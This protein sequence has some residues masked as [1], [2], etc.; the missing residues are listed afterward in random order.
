MRLLYA[1]DVDADQI[2]ATIKSRGGIQKLADEAAKPRREGAK[3]GATQGDAESEQENGEA[4]DDAEL[5]STDAGDGDSEENGDQNEDP[6][7]DVEE[8]ADADQGGVRFH[9]SEKLTE[10]IRKCRGKRIKIIARVPRK[11]NEKVRVLKVVSLKA[12]TQG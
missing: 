12:A 2:A 10:K 1:E 6:V 11:M 7:G 3:K 4:S 8:A 9:I 5:H